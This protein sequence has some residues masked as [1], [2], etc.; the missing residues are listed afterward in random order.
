M[1]RLG[2]VLLLAACGGSSS[3]GDDDTS[4]D[5]H[6]TPQLDPNQ[7]TAFALSAA[8]AATTC[9]TP[10]PSGGQALFEQWCRKGVTVAAQCGGNPAGGLACFASPDASDWVCELG[11][12]Y[13]ACGGDLAS[14]LGAY[15]LI[16]SGN[17]SCE[18]GITCDF[19]VDCSGNSACNSVTKQCF[20]KVAYCIGLPCDF[21]VDCPSNEK[22]NSSEHACVAN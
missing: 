17:P 6:V 11:Q 14:A 1:K 3:N 19:D 4:V 8:T 18:S 7:C 21:D 2:F 16:A 10:L 20:S 5:A 15:C 22:C 9:G 12:P 13:P